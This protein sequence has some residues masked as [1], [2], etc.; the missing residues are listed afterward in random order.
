MPANPQPNPAQRRRLRYAEHKLKEAQQKLSRTER[1][2]L[3][4]SRILADLKH[5]RIRAIQPPLWPE[6][7][8]PV[9]D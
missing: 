8:T 3:Y 4:W 6:E 1:S 5:E 9:K 7:E 2:I